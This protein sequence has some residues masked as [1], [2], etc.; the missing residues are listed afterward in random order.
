[1]IVVEHVMCEINSQKRYFYTQYK[2]HRKKVRKDAKEKYLKKFNTCARTRTYENLM[3]G[4][5]FYEREHSKPL[6]KKYNFLTVHN[7]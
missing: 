3:L 2:E 5:E 6:F 7:L 4:T 1:M